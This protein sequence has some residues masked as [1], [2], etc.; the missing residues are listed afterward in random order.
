MSHNSKIPSYEGEKFDT[1]FWDLWN[2]VENGSKCDR[3]KPLRKGLTWVSIWEG[4]KIV[5]VK[6]KIIGALKTR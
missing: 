4:L 6:A 2:S 5:D 1:Q 3:C